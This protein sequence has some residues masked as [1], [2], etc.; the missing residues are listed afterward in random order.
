M[1]MKPV[2]R[3]IKMWLRCDAQSGYT[4]DFNIYAGRETEAQIGTLGERVV[5]SLASTIR[6]DDVTLCFDRFFT[7]VNLL[8]TIKYPALGTCMSN[9]RN[10]PKI[11]TKLEKSQYVFKCTPKGLL[12]VKWRDT[13]DVCVLSNCHSNDVTTVKKTQ[14]D[15]KK[16]T[17]QCPAMIAFYREIMGGVDLADQMSGLYELDRKSTKWWK[18]IFYR[19][20]M[21]AAVNS[22]IIYCQ[23]KK[24][25]FLSKV[26]LFCLL[27]N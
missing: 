20:M 6:Q 23:L 22:W 13:K 5:N 12:Y 1:P 15:G 17:V 26:F 19:L 4:Y 11:D 3:G 18:K 27:K 9:R 10:L 8:E 14:K 16:V 7:T 25:K 2:K 24:K 21:M